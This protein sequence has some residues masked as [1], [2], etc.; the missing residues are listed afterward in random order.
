[1]DIAKQKYLDLTSMSFVFQSGAQPLLKS[2]GGPRFGSQHRGACARARTKAGLGVGCG[3]GL[4][5]PAV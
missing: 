4:P 5:P 1:M 2:W 3:R